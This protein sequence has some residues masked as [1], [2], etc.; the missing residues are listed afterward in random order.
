MEIAGQFDCCC[1]HQWVASP[2]LCLCRG[3]WWT[4]WAHFTMNIGYVVQCFKLMLSKFLNLGFLLFDCFVYRQ[5]HHLSEY[6]L[7]SL[8]IV[9]GVAL[10]VLSAQP[11]I[12]VNN[13]SRRSHSVDNNWQHRWWIMVQICFFPLCSSLCWYY[14]YFCVCFCTYVCYMYS[15]K[16]ARE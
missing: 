16:R 1:S 9:F 5:K 8:L 13:R 3:S 12:T 6:R 15:I 4:F 11:T 10:H 14:F 7:A 2:S